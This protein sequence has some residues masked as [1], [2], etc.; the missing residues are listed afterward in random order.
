MTAH[1][2]TVPWQYAVCREEDSRKAFA[3]DAARMLELYAKLTI[4]EREALDNAVKRAHA[5]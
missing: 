2:K 5:E 3:S 4:R 1:P